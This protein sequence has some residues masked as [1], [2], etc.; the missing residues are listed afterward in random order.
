MTSTVTRQE[1][2]S[3]EEKAKKQEGVIEIYIRRKR[4]SESRRIRA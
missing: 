1:E 4:E 3:L 2:R